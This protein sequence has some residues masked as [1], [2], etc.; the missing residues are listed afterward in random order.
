VTDPAQAL[1]T[2]PG[3]ASV[4]AGL[5]AEE[6]LTL[7][8]AIVRIETALGDVIDKPNETPRKLVQEL[9]ELDM[10]RQTLEALGAVLGLLAREPGDAGL[11]A[12][13]RTVPLETLRAR[14]LCQDRPPQETEI[15]FF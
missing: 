4:L 8:Q 1:A 13:I 11:I 12:G 6:V 10:L 5:C 2:A 7:A 3:V 14:L 9:Q 15:E